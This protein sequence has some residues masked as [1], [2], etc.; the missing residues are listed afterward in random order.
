MKLFKF[1]ILAATM[2][3]FSLSA[4]IEKMDTPWKTPPK[5]LS[6]ETYIGTL[7]YYA[8]NFPDIFKLEMVAKSPKGLP[9]YLCKLT[10]SN[11]PDDDK[12]IILI[13]ALHSGA[14]R[15]GTAGLMEFLKIMAGNSD[16][17]KT[18]LKKNIILVMPMVNPEG[19]FLDEAL[20]NSRRFDPY[21]IGRG[22]RVDLKTLAPKVPEDGPEY[23]A[24]QRIA[25]KYKP[26]FHM[27]VHGTGL[28]FN[29]YI[30]PM[31]V[32]RAGSNSSIGP[33]DGKLYQALLA[34]APK[35][36]FGAS[37]M[38]DGERLIWGPAMEK[39]YQSFFDMGQPYYYG[40]TY[41]YIR[42]HTM[43]SL[44]ESTWTFSVTE[45]LKALLEEANKGFS[46]HRINDFKV[47]VIKGGI[48]TSLVS[49]GKTKAERRESRVNL[50]QKQDFFAVGSS[51]PN[52]GNFSVSM[53]AYG[54]EGLTTLLGTADSGRWG[55]AMFTDILKNSE[56]YSYIDHEGLKKFLSFAPPNV[57]KIMFE[58]GMPPA[59]AVEPEIGSGLGILYNIPVA[60]A[61]ILEINLN[62]KIVTPGIEDGYETWVEDGFTKVL[63]NIPPERTAREKLFL[64]GVAWNAPFDIH[65]Q[66]GYIPDETI[67]NW[68]RNNINN[69]AKSEI[70][71]ASE[72]QRKHIEE[73][74]AKMQKK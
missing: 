59:D 38:E 9:V 28:H 56:N 27:D 54:K 6:L 43:L 74:R 41:T 36:G 2:T 33:W 63:V 35:A 55:Q 67:S 16:L 14:E 51:Y 72:I 22:N 69:K 12:N 34:S 7:Y 52:S 49:Y 61:E 68:I 39:H 62:G 8:Q 1:L 71:D 42:N 23:I 45:P 50:W 40:A 18:S 46:K 73:R 60:N 20:W 30:Q 58:K 57:R 15:T 44:I 29:A 48:N 19:F 37:C 66:Y 21:S 17:A 25:D 10:D 53:I 5:R 31:T 64:L 13:T 4:S 65:S 3:G 26:D 70:Q 11:V 32:G 47:N 24:F